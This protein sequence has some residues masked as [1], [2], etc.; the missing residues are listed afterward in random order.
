MEH[1]VTPFDGIRNIS[2]GKVTYTKGCDPW[3]N[4]RSGFPAAVIAAKQADVAIV[5]V[6]TWSRDQNELWKGLNATTG[7][8]VDV[9]TLKLVGAMGPL[10]NAIIEIG[11]PTIIVYSSGKPVTEPWISKRAAAVLQQFYPSEQGGHALAD[12]LYGN[13]N[14]SGRLSVGIPY[15]VGTTPIFYDYLNSG[16]TVDPGEVDDD[17]S[18]IQFGHQYVDDTPEPLYEFGFGKSYSTFSYSNVTLSAK[19]A[20]AKDTITASVTVWNTSKRDGSEVVQLYVE[21][22]ISSIVVPN[23][24]LKGFKKVF[25]KAGGKVDI[26]IPV[27]VEDLGL[28]NIQ[29]K[30]VVEPGEFRFWIGASSKDMKTKAIL[31]VT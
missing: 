31:T 12:I 28:W 24:Q 5:I 22:L 9:S 14:P 8:H 6:G 18:I 11:K 29:M 7:E 15:D 30:Y 2:T 4:D 10:V 20:T 21:D 16:R 26:D 1:G 19:N 23:K 3:S 25:I 13:V 27:K 17:G